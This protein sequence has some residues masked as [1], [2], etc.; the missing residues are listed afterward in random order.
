[1]VIPL[2]TVSR[3]RLL[4]APGTR[5]QL[6]R[7]LAA[8]NRDDPAR[9]RLRARIIENDLPMA[10]RLARRYVGRGEPYDRGQALN[11]PEGNTMAAGPV[12][13]TEP[14]T[15][16]AGSS[17]PAR[18]GVW[19]KRGV[20]LRAFRLRVFLLVAA[21]LLPLLLTVVLGDR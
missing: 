12:V 20:A 19:V 2:P 13:T 10:G 16:L 6:L 18:L 17:A 8:L 4:H 5:E 15:I 11:D 7:R 14:S 9:A 21:L 3:T 1:M